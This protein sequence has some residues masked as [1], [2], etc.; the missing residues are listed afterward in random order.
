MSKSDESKKLLDAMRSSHVPPE[1]RADMLIYATASAGLDYRP[2]V[3]ELIKEADEGRK[4]QAKAKEDERQLLALEAY[5]GSVALGERQFAAVTSGSGE[6]FL[7]C[8]PDEIAGL[9][10]GDMVLVDH[11]NTR[12][13]GRDGQMPRPGEVVTVD[14]MHTPGLVVVRHH[15]QLIVARLPQRLMHLHGS[16]TPGTRVVYD[17]V[18]K[19]VYQVIDT[20]SDGKELLTDVAVLDTVSRADLG[21][22][23]PM[24]ERILFRF[25][26]WVSHPDWVKRMGVRHRMSYMFVGP[27]GSGKS[28][29]LQVLGREASDFVHEVTGQ[30]VSRLVMCDA[31]DFYS[32]LFGQAEIN[33]NNWFEKLKR[34][35]SI[36][37]RDRSG[38]PVLVPLIVV[39]EEVEA[40]VRTRGE[41]GGSSHLFDRLLALILQKL[42][43]LAGELGFPI[44]FCSTTNRPDLVDPAARRRLGVR[45]VMLGTLNA[46]QA[47][48]V[49]EKKVTAEMALGNGDGSTAAERRHRIINQVISYLY[50]NDPEQGIAEVQLANSERPT[51]C[52]RDVV[53]GSMLEEAVSVA[54]DDSLV[55]SEKAGELVGIDGPGIIRALRDQF[56]S[57]AEALRPHNLREHC[58]E[59]FADEPI[60]V[61]SVRPL[62]RRVRRPRSLLMR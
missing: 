29:H 51:L 44:I 24:L 16:L 18:R 13:V 36:E 32:P 6:V 9:E 30:R 40:L 22:P 45:Q 42:S 35:G 43:S 49:L 57:L 54:V 14:S 38:R 46:N 41:F 5:L 27:T 31:S 3:A 7:P 33:I 12:I 11:K 1:A 56:V 59:W 55:Q 47:R 23:H 2:A 52:R 50:G 39:L 26:M 17:P 58:P 10:R 60:H 20:Q 37:L 25:K 21:A 28:L 15:E 53:T 34:L 61:A 19:F 4:L 48:S 8:R 62:V